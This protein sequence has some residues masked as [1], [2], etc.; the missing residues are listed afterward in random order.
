MKRERDK[1]MKSLLSLLFFP[2]FLFFFVFFDFL[3]FCQNTTVFC[4]LM[5]ERIFVANV[6]SLRNC[7]L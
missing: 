3:I 6:L 1:K 5:R 2:F 7:C 4:F